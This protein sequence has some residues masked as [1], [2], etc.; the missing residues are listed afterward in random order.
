MATFA[1][2]E[3][4]GKQYRVS[5]GDKLRVEKLA[6]EA[7]AEVRF[8]KVLLRADGDAVNVGAPH[9]SGATV[10]AKVLRQMRDRKKIIFRYHSKTRYRKTRGHRQELTEIEITNV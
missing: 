10:T 5:S 1:V 8:D 6:G 3:T 4:G 9:V 2:I 7:G